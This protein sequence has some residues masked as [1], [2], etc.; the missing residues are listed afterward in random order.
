MSIQDETDMI[1]IARLVVGE[2]AKSHMHGD[3]AE[4]RRITEAAMIGFLAGY[5]A[6]KTEGSPDL[7]PVYRQKMLVTHPMVAD[8]I[9]ALTARY[10]VGPRPGLAERFTK[11]LKRK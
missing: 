9:A 8:G 7:A 6:A 2:V 3:I 5:F 4:M 11:K 10:P 1:A